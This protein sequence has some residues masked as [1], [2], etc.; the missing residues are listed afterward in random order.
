M[1]VTAHLLKRK[2]DKTINKMKKK[3]RS[4]KKREQIR[5]YMA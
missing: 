2:K 5:A 1:Y 3:K 4:E